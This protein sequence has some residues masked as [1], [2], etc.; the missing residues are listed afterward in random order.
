MQHR[1][2]REVARALVVGTTL[3][4]AALGGTI[5][6]AAGRGSRSLRSASVHAPL[7]TTKP[8]GTMPCPNSSC[9]VVIKSNASASNFRVQAV[10]TPPP[11][12]PQSAAPAPAGKGV[13]TFAQNSDN[14]LT[15][16]G[17]TPHDSNSFQFY[18][19]QS[20]L[21]NVLYEITY[22]VMNTDPSQA[23]FCLGWRFSFKTKGGKSV[24]QDLPNG[25]SGFVG[26]LPR[27]TADQ[28]GQLVPCL[29]SKAKS[30]SNTILSAQVPA[31]GGDPWGRS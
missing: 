10:A 5:T 2:H 15:C 8:N 26:L 21:G 13:L 31:I 18:L 1:I 27:C 12:A 11:S 22:T 30:G 19:G 6:T 25:R 29:L 14:P 4:C 7:V 28:V 9:A 23:Q 3:A 20:T 16:S 24:R 17:Y